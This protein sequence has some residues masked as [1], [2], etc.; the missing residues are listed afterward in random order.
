MNKKLDKLFSNLEVFEPE[1]NLY[2]KILL[3]INRKQRAFVRRRFFVFLFLFLGSMIA[4][5]PTIKLLYTDFLQS[6]FIQFFSLIFSDS[7]A[8]SIYW[9]NFVLVLLES[10][11]IIS[12]IM[13]F[14]IIFVLLESLRFLSHDIKFIFLHNN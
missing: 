3:N 12:T 8:I 1:A 14:G 10:L 6:G 7:Q 5:V 13:F 11:P 2:N 4:L 9:K